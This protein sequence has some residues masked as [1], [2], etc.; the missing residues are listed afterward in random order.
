MPNRSQTQPI[1]V[2]VAQLGTPDAPT[3]EALRPYLRQFL[4]DRR[5]VD[6]NPL[7][8]QTILHLIVLRRRPARSAA[9][10]RNIWTEQGSPLLVHSRAQVAGLQEQLGDGYKVVLGMRYGSPSI[11]SAL[12]ELKQAGIDRMLIFPM[13]PQFSSATTGSIY[14][15][16]NQ[17][18]MSQRTRNMPTLRF[19]PPYYDHPGYI[20]ALKVTVEEAVSLSKPNKYL[21]SFHGI[22]QRY[23]D[24]GDPYRLHSEITAQRLAEALNLSPDRWTISFQSQF[25]REAWLQPYTD[26]MLHDLGE[27][28]VR[29]LAVACPGFTADCLETLDEVGR[30]GAHQFSEAGGEDFKLVPCLNGHPVWLDAMADIVREESMGWV[31]NPSPRRTLYQLQ[32]VP[33]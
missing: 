17:A 2:L 15:A 23:V 12:A 7:V 21:F 32:P 13:Y 27:S 14:D 1:G 5:V 31:S 9:L 6:Y 3:A 28:A 30:E 11:P 8:W 4:S 18:A 25:G 26:D 33:G 22:P 20:H 16:V 29:S 19:V 24:E 10:Y